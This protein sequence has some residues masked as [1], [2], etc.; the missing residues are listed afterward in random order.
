VR[1]PSGETTG[2]ART[3]TPYHPKMDNNFVRWATFAAAVLGLL[4]AAQRVY[5]SGQSL[6]LWRSS[7]QD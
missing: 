2:D 6:G 3:S 5:K 1:H 7:E 4:V